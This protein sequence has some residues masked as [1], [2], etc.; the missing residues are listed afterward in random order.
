MT[1]EEFYN[2]AHNKPKIIAKSIYKLTICGY[3]NDITGYT[4]VPDKQ[5]W[6]YP[7]YKSEWFFSSKEEAEK[8]MNHYIKSEKGTIHSFLI[9]RVTI[10][11]DIIDTQYLEWWNYDHKGNMI[12]SSLCTST[13]PE[14]DKLTIDNIFLGRIPESYPFQIGDIVEIISGDRVHL[15]ILNGLPQTVNDCWERYEERIN[16]WGRKP[17]GPYYHSSY[18]SDCLADQFFYL[19]SDGFDPD[20]APYKVMKPR[21]PIPEKA[22]EI[23]TARYK[24]WISD[25]D[26]HL[27]GE[28]D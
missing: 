25:I 26:S 12:M 19:L 6:I 17:E 27:S 24:R 1:K 18:F 5:E 28:I 7:I 20:V 14:Y 22:K 3:R 9:S 8:A 21:F 13:I 2:L 15:E 4:L 23:L 11:T 10:D 16:R